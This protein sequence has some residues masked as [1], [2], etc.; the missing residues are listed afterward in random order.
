MQIF[1][2]MLAGMGFYVAG[3]ALSDCVKT[4]IRRHSKTVIIGIEIK[5][6]G[7]TVNDVFIVHRRTGEVVGHRTTPQG[8]LYFALHRGCYTVTTLADNRIYKSD[9]YV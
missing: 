8:K 2:F 1:L 3:V 4:L 6:E 9:L 7:K 5:S